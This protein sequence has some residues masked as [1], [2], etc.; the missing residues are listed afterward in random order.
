MTDVQQK[1][2]SHEEHKRIEIL[3]RWVLGLATIAIAAGFTFA[4]NVH[5][6][7][8]VLESQAA[9]GPRYT[10]NDHSVYSKS[11]DRR[12]TRLETI[13]ENLTPRMERIDANLDVLADEVRRGRN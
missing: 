9:S 11:V 6:R 2:S 5:G 8:S 3:V 7:I 1:T 10:L 4:F 13:L 12:L